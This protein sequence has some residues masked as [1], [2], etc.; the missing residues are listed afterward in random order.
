MIMSGDCAAFE[1]I[2]GP[3]IT[4]MQS[5]KDVVRRDEA[6]FGSGPGRWA[7]WKKVWGRS[8]VSDPAVPVSCELGIAVMQVLQRIA[9]YFVRALRELRILGPREEGSR[10]VWDPSM[11]LKS[12]HDRGRGN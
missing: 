10:A 2:S 11:G 1:I 7:S 8:K 12:A 4:P 9:I 3:H 5:P 6:W